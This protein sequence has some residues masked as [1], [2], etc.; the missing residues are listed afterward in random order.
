[1]AEFT[2]KDRSFSDVCRA[3]K[4]QFQWESWNWIGLTFV[5]DGDSGAFTFAPQF[6]SES[7]C[8]CIKSWSST[9]GN[10]ASPSTTAAAVVSAAEFDL[11]RARIRVRKWHDQHQ[12]QL[13]RPAHARHSSRS[14]FQ[15]QGFRRWVLNLIC[16]SP[17][18]AKPGMTAIK[19][20]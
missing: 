4:Q 10:S 6:S 12:Q 16:H 11:T 5:V 13:H 18:Q 19:S 2:F 7:R 20:N 15:E 14:G 1:M 3:D 17:S 8:I 9:A